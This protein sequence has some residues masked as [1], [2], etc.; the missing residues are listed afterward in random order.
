MAKHTTCN[1][2]YLKVITKTDEK[3]ILD[4]KYSQY[5]RPRNYKH[6]LNHVT[7]WTTLYSQHILLQ[8]EVK[9]EDHSQKKR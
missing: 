9:L 8:Q 2:H 4:W 3:S 7:A 6:N 5:D 1:L